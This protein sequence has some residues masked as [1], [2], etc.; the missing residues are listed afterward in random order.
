M[1]KVRALLMMSCI[2][3]FA[4]TMLAGCS[5]DKDFTYS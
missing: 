3:L 1:K 5:V 2:V 4:V